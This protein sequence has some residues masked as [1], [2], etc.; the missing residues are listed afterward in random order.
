[1]CGK[2]ISNKNNFIKI[3]TFVERPGIPDLDLLHN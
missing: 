2:K 3:S 1:M